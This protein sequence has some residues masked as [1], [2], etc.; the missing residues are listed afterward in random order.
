MPKSKSEIADL[1]E[2][3]GKE[4]D[5]ILHWLGEDYLSQW[6]RAQVLA[7]KAQR[8]AKEIRKGGPIA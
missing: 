5:D 7:T 6:S 1:L 3:L 8:W 2:N 4:A